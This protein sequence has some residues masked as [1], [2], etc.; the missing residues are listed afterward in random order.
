MGP[1]GSGKTTLAQKI[2]KKTKLPLV[3]IDYHFLKDSKNI[4]DKTIFNKHLEKLSVKIES[5]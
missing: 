3:H 2:A 5:K 1:P 4:P